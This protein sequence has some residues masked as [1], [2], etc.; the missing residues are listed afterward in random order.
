D[1]AGRVRNGESASASARCSIKP[2]NL[3]PHAPVRRGSFYPW[4]LNA[5]VVASISI[6]NKSRSASHG[7]QVPVA[8]VVP[9]EQWK[10]AEKLRD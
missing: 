6:P 7:L 4:G 3:F 1:H 10:H 9:H 5:S 8:P 2:V